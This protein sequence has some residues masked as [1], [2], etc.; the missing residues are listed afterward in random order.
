MA[1]VGA[2][3]LTEPDAGRTLKA[4]RTRRGPRRRRLVLDGRKPFYHNRQ[5][6]RPV[7]VAAVNEPGAGSRGISQYPRGRPRPASRSPACSTRS[8]STDR[9]TAELSSASARVRAARRIG[10]RLHD[11]GAA[12]AGAAVR[13][14][15]RP[16]ATQAVALTVDYTSQRRA[17]GAPL[18]DLQN[19]RLKWPERGDQ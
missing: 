19:T 17:S 5:H 3:A 6:R 2:I 11:D 16:S 12:P 14:R 18:S 10:L 15:Q 7:V 4:L 13:R 8:A 9:I 1:T